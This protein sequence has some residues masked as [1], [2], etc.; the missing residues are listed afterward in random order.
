MIR[1]HPAPAAAVVVVGQ[2]LEQAPAIERRQRVEA[3]A[4]P[5]E[6]IVGIARR[7]GRRGR[8]QRGQRPGLIASSAARLTGEPGREVAQR[9]ADVARLVGQPARDGVEHLVGEVLGVGHRRV[10]IPRDQA[11]PEPLVTRGGVGDIRIERAEQLVPGLAGECGIRHPQRHTQSISIFCSDLKN[12]A[13][14]GS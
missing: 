6:Q 5:V 4:Q 7:G 12:S 3:A 1:E 8:G 13:Q 9:G 11:P 10:A 14:T 2:V